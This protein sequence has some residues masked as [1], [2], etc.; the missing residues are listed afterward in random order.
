MRVAWAK[1]NARKD[2]WSEEVQ[3]LRE[4]MRRIINSFDTKAHWWRRR[5]H[6]RT[7][8][9]LAVQR[10]AAAYAMRQGDMF[11]AMAHSCAAKWYPFLV[12]KQLSVCWIPDYIPTTHIP[13]RPRHTDPN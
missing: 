13:Y 6:R 9:P 3:M 1:S 7:D 8:A 4:E 12:F 11:V 5:A 10:G 2:R